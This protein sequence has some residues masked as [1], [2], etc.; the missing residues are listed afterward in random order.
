MEV[1]RSFLPTLKAGFSVSAHAV[2]EA[3]LCAGLPHRDMGSRQRLGCRSRA[4]LW[5]TLGRCRGRHGFA[6]AHPD[7]QVTGH[8]HHQSL[9]RPRPTCHPVATP[10]GCSFS[11]IQARRLGLSQRAP[12]NSFLRPSLA[13]HGGPTAKIS[14]TPPTV[15]QHSAH[16]QP[17]SSRCASI[18][19]GSA[20]A[21]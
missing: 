15:N 13:N 11:T 18:R 20:R 1:P 12:L 17:A 4:A 7:Q 9:P 5:A 2:L 3:A 6:R 10:T 8:A 21:P 16:A 19:A 14:L